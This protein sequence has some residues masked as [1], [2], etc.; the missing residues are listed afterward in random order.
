MKITTTKEYISNIPLISR[1]S[2]CLTAKFYRITIVDF[3][4]F[5]IVLIG[6]EKKREERENNNQ[7][8]TPNNQ[9]K[10]KQ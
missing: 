1:L 2:Y 6:N 5:K 9:G 10:R 3:R 7:Y 8:P 4:F